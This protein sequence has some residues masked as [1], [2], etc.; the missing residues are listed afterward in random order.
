MQP[1]M[2]D[3]PPTANIYRQSSSISDALCLSSQLEEKPRQTIAQTQWLWHLYTE[4]IQ[5]EEREREKKKE[6]DGE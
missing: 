3:F 4:H 6:T 5:K 2:L 1:D